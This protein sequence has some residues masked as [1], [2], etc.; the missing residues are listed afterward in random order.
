M[1]SYERAR[2][3][4]DEIKGFYGHLTAYI[5][6]NIAI[7]LA[8]G[9]FIFTLLSRDAVGNHDFLNW[10]DWNVYG[11]AIVWGVGLVIHGIH[12]FVKN[13]FFGKAWEEKQ[14]RK[15]LDDEKGD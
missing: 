3:R 9:K 15:L 4:V 1:S 10:V 5:I 2:K 12:V 13:P 14:I 11:T 7:I 8:K 6:V